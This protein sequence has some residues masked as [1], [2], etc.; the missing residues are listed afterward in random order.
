M[1]RPC[2]L[3]SFHYRSCNESFAILAQDFLFGSHIYEFV[4]LENIK[5]NFSH[6]WQNAE[7]LTEGDVDYAC[8]QI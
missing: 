3:S 1:C 5:V 7:G 8:I 6:L 2:E 4:L